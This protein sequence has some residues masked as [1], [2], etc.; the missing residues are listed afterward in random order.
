VTNPG[1]WDEFEDPPSQVPPWLLPLGSAVMLGVW[2]FVAIPPLDALWSPVRLLIS[3]ALA[4]GVRAAYLRN[5]RRP[6]RAFWSHWVAL[7]ALISGVA[8][9]MV[10]E[11]MRV[12]HA[13]SL[14]V[15]YHLADSA[16]S[17]TIKQRC[18]AD[19]LSE[20]DHMSP[21]E[22]LTLP[23]GT[24]KWL[25]PR[26]CA[27]GIGQGLVAE[28]GQM[29]KHSGSVLSSQVV[30]EFGTSRVL[31]MTGNFLAVEYGFAASTKSATRSQR[32]NAFVLRF[33]DRE[34]A[35]GVTRSRVVKQVRGV[36]SR[37]SKLGLVPTSGRMT[38]NDIDRVVGGAS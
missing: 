10:G 9:F 34:Q 32:C 30:E 24:T 29:S 18:V 13:N 35:A 38:D 27:L 14:A 12:A 33:Y 36:C 26:V 2:V 31:T 25:A 16:G 1:E 20:W 6:M 23:R 22:Q 17:A 5:K 7:L 11:H 28:D 37:G 8:T 4:A 21:A 3:G 15:K 19:M